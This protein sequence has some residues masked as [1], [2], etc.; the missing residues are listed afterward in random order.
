VE[1]IHW[2]GQKSEEELAWRLLVGA[3]KGIS[4]RGMGW[5]G[6]HLSYCCFDVTFAFTIQKARQCSSK[7]EGPQ[8]I[9]STLLA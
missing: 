9:N 1:L 8:L 5:E 3:E 7:E 6:L 2:K 4:E